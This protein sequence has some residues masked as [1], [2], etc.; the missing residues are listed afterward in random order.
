MTH[1]DRKMTYM[2]NFRSSDD[3]KWIENGPPSPVVTNFH[4][5]IGRNSIQ[6]GRFLPKMTD[7]GQFSE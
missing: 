5:S 3:Q 1:F 6:D 4:S 2:A 7:C